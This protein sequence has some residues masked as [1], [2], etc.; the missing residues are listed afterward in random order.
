MSKRLQVLIDDRS[1]GL[2][3]RLAKQQQL[4]LGEW[5]R[6]ILRTA[7]QKT[8]SRPV[9]D[10]IKAIRRAAKHGFPTADIDEMISEIE[11]GYKGGGY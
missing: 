6:Q 10:K 5:V 4:S 11:R 8:A 1:Y 9:Q 2:F 7:A 3:Q